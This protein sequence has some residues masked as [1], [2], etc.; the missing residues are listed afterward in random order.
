[1]IDFAL[2][3]FGN[4]AAPCRQHS[5]FLTRIPVG[6]SEGSAKG[7]ASR[8]PGGMFERGSGARL[9]EARGHVGGTPG[10]ARGHV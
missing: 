5:E 8:T 4:I 2:S 6:T 7:H 9:R 3:Q 10:A 1:M